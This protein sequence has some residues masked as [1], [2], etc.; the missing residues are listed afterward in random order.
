MRGK[1]CEI[2]IFC[3]ILPNIIVINNLYVGSFIQ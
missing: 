2:E 1:D 3:L